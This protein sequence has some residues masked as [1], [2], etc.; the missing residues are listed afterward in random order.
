[1][2]ARVIIAPARI[3]DIESIG[4]IEAA[5]FAQPWQPSALMAELSVPESW[6]HIAGVPAPDR[7]RTVVVGYIM[8]RFLTDEMH[9]MKL[10]VDPAWRKRGVAT[11]LL[12]AAQREARRRRAAVM[13]LEVRPS[14]RAAIRFYRKAG[15]HTIGI[16]PNY[17]PQTGE[18]ALVMSKRLKEEP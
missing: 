1:M 12:E 6:H 10:A 18:D 5:S 3:E 9:I 11:A 7:K 8:V 14:N 4:A 13:L 16:R 17:Y 15:F 2:T